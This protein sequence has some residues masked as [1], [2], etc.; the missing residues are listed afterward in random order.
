MSNFLWWNWDEVDYLSWWLR[1]EVHDSLWWL[2]NILAH[3]SWWLW[4]QLYNLSW[5]L[6]DGLNNLL[7]WL[8]DIFALAADD[9]S[10][11][12]C[13]WLTNV[14]LVL[15]WLKGNWSLDWLGQFNWWLD[16][17]GHMRLEWGKFQDSSFTTENVNISKFL[18]YFF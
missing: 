10:D 4:N 17:L 5:W 3:L 8:W 18:I 14:W 12:D 7:W 6:W 2:W 15:V 13:G 9:S 16:V 1:N 11:G